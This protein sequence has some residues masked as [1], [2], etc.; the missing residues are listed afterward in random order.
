[1]IETSYFILSREKEP[2]LHELIEDFAIAVD[3][4]MFIL[5]IKGQQKSESFNCPANYQLRKE[6]NVVNTQLQQ[7][8]ALVKKGEIQEYRCHSGAKLIPLP[9][10]INNILVGFV[11]LL[12]KLNWLREQEKQ[13]ESLSNERTEKM[14]NLFIKMTSSTLNNKNSARRLEVRHI[15][16]INDLKENFTEKEEIIKATKYIKENLSRGISLEEVANEV[17]LSQYYF[18]KLFKKEL[19]MNFVTYLNYQRVIYAKELLVHSQMTVEEISKR[20]GFS[21]TSY[22]CKIFKGIVAV[23]PA[24]YRKQ[25]EASEASRKV[26]A[27]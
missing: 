6:S 16:E 7:M 27:L 26:V 19:G 8:I 22:F 4:G 21:Q 23:S 18:S 5:D 20:A 10:Y 3:V 2:Q 14:T 9:V 15:T 13:S 24:S 1:M 12:Q 11:M 17:Y 25:V